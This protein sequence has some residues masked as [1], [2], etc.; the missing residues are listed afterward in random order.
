MQEPEVIRK[1]RDFL[2]TQ[3]L[4][5][6]RAFDIYTDAHPS[7]TGD[8]TLGPFQ[9]FTLSLEG[10]TVHPDLVCRLDDGETLVAI[11][12]K[13]EHD[14]VKGLGQ[15]MLY[16][17]GF[18]LVLFACTNPP[19]PLITSARQQQ[20]GLLDVRPDTV[21]LLELPD[22][23]MPFRAQAQ[24]IQKQFRT[25]ETVTG[26]F[27]FNLPT[28]Y[29]S[30]AIALAGQGSW[31]LSELEQVLRKQYQPLPGKTSEFRSVV[32]G[33]QRL[34][35]VEVRGDR[36]ALTLVGESASHLLPNL[37][38]L[39]T[40]HQ[41]IKPLRGPTL[42]EASPPS[43]AV[44]RWLLSTNAVVQ[45]IVETLGT[46]N[47]GPLTM[48]ALVQRALERDKGQ[49]LVAF[50]TPERLSEIMDAHDNIIWPHVTA[51]HYR[52]TTYLQLKSILKHAGILAPRP[53]GGSSST[54][55]D[56]TQD[57]WE[58]GTS[59]INLMSLRA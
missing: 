53:L 42:D 35:L 1:T 8:A 51:R 3:G 26:S 50:F 58:L 32:R 37:A 27:V 54:T 33:A 43:G 11:E 59:L 23:H 57:I 56:P 20:V 24:S 7:L 12:A 25:T 29:L 19:R 34:G 22:V 40:I 44:L 49:A 14:H 30:A 9:R 47:G 45:L 16:R 17:H 15:A 13:G 38:S 4:A 52:S 46:L 28:H 10:M 31:S 48:P 39:A 36:V 2:Q 18:H 55:Y 41:I 5:G 21:T 6:R